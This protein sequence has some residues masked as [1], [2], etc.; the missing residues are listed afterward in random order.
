MEI[1]DL[2]SSFVCGPHVC[3]SDTVT[4]SILGHDAIALKWLKEYSVNELGLWNGEQDFE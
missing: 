4:R 3:A 2:D 1:Y